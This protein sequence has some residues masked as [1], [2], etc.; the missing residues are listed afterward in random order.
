MVAHSGGG[1][2]QSPEMPPAF[3]GR[4]AR[5]T[6]TPEADTEYERQKRLFIFR[7]GFGC[8]CLALPF[9]YIISH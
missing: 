3:Q 6:D 8:I 9:A 4:F 7:A 5:H 2:G 1:C